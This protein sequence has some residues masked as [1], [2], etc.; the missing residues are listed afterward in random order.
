MDNLFLKP[1]SKFVK[2]KCENCG[3]Q[4]IVFQSSATVFKCL[5]C[6]AVLVEPTG[7][8]AK[9]NGSIVKVLD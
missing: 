7:G 2:V 5:K 9:I 3:N 8:K 1:K 6:N 4:Q